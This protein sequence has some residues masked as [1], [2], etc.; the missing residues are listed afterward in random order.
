MS[1][2]DAAAPARLAQELYDATMAPLAA[3]RRAEG[4]A[5][6][7]PMGPDP[8]ATSYF[9][10]PDCSRMT[11]AD[12]EFPG[13]GDAEG[14]V[15]ALEASWMASGDGDLAALAPRLK[16]IAAALAAIGD[17]PDGDIDALCYTMF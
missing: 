10:T 12:F 6:T 8:E 15:D 9:E 7:F 3:S 5:E 1:S 11:A 4:R 13:G 17:E 16:A 14:L 2:T